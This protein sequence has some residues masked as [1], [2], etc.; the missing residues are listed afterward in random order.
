[1]KLILAALAVLVIGAGCV[2]GGPLADGPEIDLCVAATWNGEPPP[3]GS[4]ALVDFYVMEEGVGH[5]AL[6]AL[7]VPYPDDAGVLVDTFCYPYDVPTTGARVTYRYEVDLT[8][9]DVTYRADDYPD[10]LICES[11]VW[12]WWS[13]FAGAIFCSERDRAGGVEPNLRPIEGFGA[14]PGGAGG[15]LVRVTTL[16]DAGPGSLREAL[17]GSNRTISVEVVGTIALASKISV[18]GDH[19][20]LLGNGIT[21]APPAEGVALEF[22]G[23]SYFVVRNVR[24]FGAVGDTGDNI[25]AWQ[26]CHHFAFDG[27]S[28]YEAGDGDLDI[29]Q[30]CTD[31]TVQFSFLGRNAKTMLVSY[32]AQERGS[33]L[34]CLFF[35]AASRA[36]QFDD[37]G[38]VQ[39]VG[40]VVYG[41]GGAQGT[42]V[43]QG[44]TADFLSNVWLPHVDGTSDVPRAI[45]AEDDAT[46]LYLGTGAEA[47]V[48]PASCLAI[49]EAGP[50]LR[51]TPLTLPAVT[52]RTAADA[53][54]LVLAT[55]G[56]V[57]RT[58]EEAAW[59][60]SV[61][62]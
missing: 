61:P 4:T 57:P 9:N 32:G 1:M 42:R 8:V 50:W 40:N 39:F 38:S 37:V 29:S 3:A 60:A 27:V 20:T 54:D 5:W 22:V 36:P 11:G 58:A 34:Y 17:A 49:L 33:V 19:F 7:D 56:A 59:I 30:S 43:R 31:W 48:V 35:E 53:M 13:P 10:E 23:A 52:V 28:T 55:A 44:T 46:S 51:A 25:R 16:E 12:W 45:L 24:V 47:N 14:N 21:V 26:S 6:V 15:E 18:T 62:R 2:S 41:W